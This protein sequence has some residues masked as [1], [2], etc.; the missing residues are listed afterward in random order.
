[1]LPKK[2]GEMNGHPERD[3]A[4]FVDTTRLGMNKPG[5]VVDI[6]CALKRNGFDVVVCFDPPTSPNKASLESCVN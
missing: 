6:L 5:K 1:M 2:M 4:V 3:P